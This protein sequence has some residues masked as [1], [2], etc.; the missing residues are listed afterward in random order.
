MK[1]MLDT[2]IN[3]MNKKSIKGL[4]LLLLFTAFVACNEN[5]ND[6]NVYTGESFVSFGTTTSASGAES[7]T[8]EIEIT[9]YASIPNL[10][11]DVTVSVQI[12]EENASA[13]NYTIVDG[14]SSF[15]FGKDKYSDTIKIKPVDNFDEDGTKTI[16][17]TL[18]SAPD[19][20]N[21][22]FPG[23][24]GKNKTF[25]VTLTDDDCAIKEDN[26][27]GAPSGSEVTGSRSFASKLTFKADPDK[28]STATEVYLLMSGNIQE[29]YMLDAWNEAIVQSWDIPVKLDFSDPQNPKV[30]FG[31]NPAADMKNYNGAPMAVAAY[32]DADSDGTADWSYGLHVTPELAKNATFSTCDKTLHFEY[33][34]TVA[35]AANPDFG[36]F[37]SGPLKVVVD[38]KF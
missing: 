7:S 4:M 5:D 38:L 34:W 22:G 33:I 1:I 27:I 32:T 18:T 13:S 16:T 14:K 25:T 6:V 12:S 19:G 8:S 20:V 28:A 9:A 23:P 3:M 24:D 15:T 30:E 2:K 26:F 17:F 11:E 10:Q 21:L 37:N 35:R 31:N 36:D 29:E